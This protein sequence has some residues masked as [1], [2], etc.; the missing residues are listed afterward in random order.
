L[1]NPGTIAQSAAARASDNRS[2]QRPG[3]VGGS[4]TTRIATAGPNAYPP[5]SLAI[6]PRHAQDMIYQIVTVI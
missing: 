1:G 3:G 5:L 6:D 2:R 4:R